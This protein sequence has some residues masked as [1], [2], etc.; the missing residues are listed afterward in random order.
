MEKKFIIIIWR[1]ET[2][3]FCAA[4]IANLDGEK[5]TK[6][7]LKKMLLI[8]KMLLYVRTVDTLL[9]GCHYNKTTETRHKKYGRSNSRNNRIGRATRGLYWC[10]GAEQT[11]VCCHSILLRERQGRLE[12][13]RGLRAYSK[14]GSRLCHQLQSQYSRTVISG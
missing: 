9:L 5:T 3:S 7:L 10:I 12:K 8:F 11:I 4:D 2:D 6:N 13:G 1:E 14:N